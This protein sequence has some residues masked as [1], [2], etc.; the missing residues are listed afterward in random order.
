MAGKKQRTSRKSKGLKRKQ[1]SARAIK[2]LECKKKRWLR[3]QEEIKTGARKGKT[4]RWNT[5]GLDRR[6]GQLRDL[7][8]LGSTTR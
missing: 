5:S 7:V 4:A 8:K 3:Y 2:V 1:R 6:L